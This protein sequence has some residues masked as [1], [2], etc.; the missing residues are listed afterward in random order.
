TAVATRDARLDPSAAPPGTPAALR[1][2]LALRGRAEIRRRARRAGA[3]GY[4]DQLDRLRASLTGPSASAAA[5][6]LRERFQVVLVDEFQDTDPVQW[7]IFRVAFAGRAAPLLLIG[8][9]K[10]AIY[11]FRGADVW[12]YLAAAGAAG[13]RA[14]LT[15]NWRSDQPLLDA[16]D[17]VLAGATLGHPEI[18]YHR[19]T[20]VENHLASGLA[21]APMP[22]PLRLRLLHRGDGL[23]ETTAQGW[24]QADSARAAVAADVADDIVDLLSS[25]ATLT[26]RAG[27]LAAVSPGDVAVLVRAN[28]EAAIINRALDAVGVPSVIAGA[29]SVFA[30]AAARYWLSL[31]EALERP[32]ATFRARAAA[33]TPFVGWDVPRLA[34]AGDPELDELQATLHRWAAVLNALGVAA[35]MEMAGT[36][37]GLA[38]RE[39]AGAQGERRLTDLRH[40]A[41]LLHAEAMGKGA[42]AR[43]LT[44][45][46]RDRISDAGGSA[47]AD[48]RSRRLET[49]AAAVQIQTIH[50]SKGLEYPI[51]Y[52]PYLWLAFPDKDPLPMYH[53]PE[54][55]DRRTID[56]GGERPE[57][58]QRHRS[59]AAEERRGEDLRQAYVALTRARHQVVTWWATGSE[60]KSSPLARL[61][62]GRGDRGTL[63][64]RPAPVPG[65]DDV[66]AAAMSELAARAPGRISVERVTPPRAR[67][68]DRPASGADALDIETF[69][70]CLDTAWGRISYTSITAARHGFAAEAGFGAEAVV[71]SEAEEPG[72][73]DEAPAPPLDGGATPSPEPDLGRSPIRDADQ[74]AVASPMAGLPAGASF[75]ILLHALCEAVDFAADDLGATVADAVAG[76]LGRPGA[77]PSG[78]GI[79]P[80]ILADALEAVIDTPLGPLVGGRALRDVSGKDRLDELRFELPLAGGDVPEGQLVVADIAASLRRWLPAGDPFAGYAERLDDPALTQMLCGYLT[81]SIDMVLRLRDPG[82]A[83]HVVV[84]YKTNWLGPPGEP[85]TAWHYRPDRLAEAMVAEHYPLQAMLYSVALHRYLRWRLAGY[86]PEQHLGGVL[87]LFVR[88][89]AGTATPTLDGAPCGVFAWNPPAGLTVELS[90]I[91]DAGGSVP[92]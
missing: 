16:L 9:P 66:V 23:V 1:V 50:R 70:R 57:G 3:V 77:H 21:G 28:S 6:R 55:E 18:T 4:D 32:A 65:D 87:Y 10:Q 59:R 7:E 68:W 12:A 56:V 79:D 11:S 53:D 54:H 60:T 8:D 52:L 37:V 74:G 86:D 61:L 14:T 2:S 46:L 85:L 41:E 22:A 75:G 89:M 33:L 20:A 84:D 42:G 88:G 91:F 24:A 29:G 83:R 45:W 34:A 71:A 73:S 69:D 67:R 64:S 39:L 36:E 63:S 80:Y 35:L 49:D 62:L 30:T 44:E 25:G 17:A 13:V 19:V 90:D 76:V 58:F 5:R 72:L 38:A 27:G 40:I 48:E 92:W 78:D 43:A 26:R 51:V 15:T 47:A 81:G 82:A 31:L